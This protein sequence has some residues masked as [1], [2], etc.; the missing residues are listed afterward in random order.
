MANSQIRV[1]VA[2]TTRI[3]RG[4]VLDDEWNSQ[5]V[6]VWFKKLKI[7]SI[8]LMHLKTTLHFVLPI[9]RWPDEHSVIIELIIF[10]KKSEMLSAIYEMLIGDWP[11]ALVNEDHI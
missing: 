3:E 9:R 5:Y 10:L 11:F 7:T 4:D 2:M 6:K 8:F 1:L